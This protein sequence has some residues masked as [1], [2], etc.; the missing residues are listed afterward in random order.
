MSPACA[1]DLG[2]GCPLRFEEVSAQPQ[3]PPG[4]SPAPKAEPVASYPEPQ[5]KP[6]TDPGIHREAEGTRS[7]SPGVNGPGRGTTGAKTENMK[8]LGIRRAL[9]GLACLEGR[10]LRVCLLELAGQHLK[11][12]RVIFHPS[13]ERHIQA[14]SG[15]SC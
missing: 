15:P 8:G 6:R 13:P 5:R 1:G 10:G 4:C 12:F 11:M 7:S 3:W 14:T 9:G 2:A